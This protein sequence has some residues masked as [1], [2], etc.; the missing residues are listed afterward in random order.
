[1]LRVCPP[2]SPVRNSPLFTT[3]LVD[4]LSPFVECRLPV[5]G[6][7]F[8]ATG[9]PQHVRL[10]RQFKDILQ[11]VNSMVPVVN[12]LSSSVSSNRTSILEQQVSLGGCSVSANSIQNI[13]ETSLHN[14]GIPQ[15]MEQ[16][17]ELRDDRSCVLEIG[18]DSI[19]EINDQDHPPSNLTLDWHAR[20]NFLPL[21][22]SFPKVCTGTA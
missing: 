12:G 18:A 13:I 10:A 1:M 14:T 7:Q 22:F 15:L 3:G 11:A 17:T 8:Q 5:I 2:T 20:R 4:R 6:D 19:T 9:I 21:K 16:L